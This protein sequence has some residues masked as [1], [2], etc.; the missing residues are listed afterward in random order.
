MSPVCPTYTARCITFL[1]FQKKKI[2]HSWNVQ[3]DSTY[4]IKNKHIDI[5]PYHYL[6][7]VNSKS[8]YVYSVKYLLVGLLRN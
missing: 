8:C 2:S 6:V 4:S 3:N 7:F 1:Y 5:I